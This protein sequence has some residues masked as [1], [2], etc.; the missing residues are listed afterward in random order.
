MSKIQE[1]IKALQLKQKKIEYVSYILDLIAN[2]TKCVDFKEVQKEICSR[3]EPFFIN[4]ITEIET[5]ATA[6]TEQQIELSQ[7]EIKVLKVVAEKLLTK[8]AAPSKDNIQP[9]NTPNTKEPEPAKKPVQQELSNTDKMAFALG[10]RHL[11]DKR[12]QVLNEHNAQIFGK[13]VGLDAPFVVVKTETGPT[14]S[15]PIEKVVLS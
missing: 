14:I 6:K 13:V 2:D 1:Q 8:P 12:V 7:E 5:D 9:L 15:V 3:I 11:A 10:N 4:L